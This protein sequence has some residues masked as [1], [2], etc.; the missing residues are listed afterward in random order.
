MGLLATD[1]AIVRGRTIAFPSADR[2]LVDHVLRCLKKKNTVSEFRTKA[3]N[4]AYRT[5][6][7]DVALCRWLPSIGI[8]PRKSLVL[9][10]IDVPDALL[11]DLMRGL[12]DGDGSIINKRAR[13]DT[14]R[15]K[16]YHW[17]YLR[18]NFLSASRAHILWLRDRID[19]AFGLEGYVAVAR[20]RKG[21][22]EMYTLRFGKRASLQLLP[23]I[24]AD[25]AAPRLTRKWRVWAEYRKRHS[26]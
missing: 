24:Y 18:T 26:I 23:R 7:G 11:V 14:K 13:A 25:P 8:M 2:E 21:R 5:Q 20:A 17:E 1:G 16:T 15:S 3:G 22:T 6:I 12:L 9:G 10:P 19:A 4:L